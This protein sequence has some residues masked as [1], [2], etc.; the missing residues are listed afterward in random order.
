MDETITPSIAV[1]KTLSD[2]A[3]NLAQN[4]NISRSQLFERAIEQFIGNNPIQPLLE[5]HTAAQ[6]GNSH[7]TINQG[8][9][10]WVQLDDASGLEPA[11]PHP[12]V[13]VQDNLF[14]HSRIHTV[15][16]CALT[17]NIKR[18]STPGN[19]LLETGE[20]NLPKQSVVETSKVSSINKAQLGE[21][22]GSLSG[23]RINQILA[24]MRF[25]QVSFFER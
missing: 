8:D 20:A 11:I 15:V 3:D 22:I 25:L 19:I 18:A 13:I 6:I 2:Q 4:L 1:P 14:N 23:Q 9:L 5:G 16:A 7:Q 10:F 21:Y 24:G 17:T 12:H